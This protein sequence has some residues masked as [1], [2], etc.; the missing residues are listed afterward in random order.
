[1][2]YLTNY[3]KNLCEQ[4]QEKV[5]ILEAQLNEAGLKAAM[6]SGDPEE[7]KKQ[8]AIQKARKENKLESAKVSGLRAIGAQTRDLK[9][10]GIFQ[11]QANAEHA[12]AL[13][14]GSNIEEIQMQLALDPS[15]NVT[16]SHY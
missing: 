4:L 5:S 2:H 7:L 16:P 14:L 13:D 9:Q 10:S 1:M 3:Y 6:K 8:L 12:S 11:R 15:M